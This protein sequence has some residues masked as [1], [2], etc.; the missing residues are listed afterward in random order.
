MS[1]AL[2]GDT[3]VACHLDLSPTDE[4]W[5]GY[6]EHLRQRLTRV[7]RIFVYAPG[8]GPTFAQQR[9]SAAFWREVDRHPPIAVITTSRLVVRAAG[10]LKWFMPSQIRAFG[11][12]DLDGAG[13]HLGFD[14][15]REGRALRTL[16]SLATK[17][18]TQ[19]PEELRR[20]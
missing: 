8:G 7:E 20:T 15:A 4:E 11:I 6:L 9:V 3:H 17:L 2:A 13:T 5:R 18:G 1:Y 14:G 12:W 10:A 19:L 16:A